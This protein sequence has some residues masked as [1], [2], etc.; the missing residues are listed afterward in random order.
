MNMQELDLVIIKHILSNKKNALEF[1]H[2][3]NEKIFSPD[4]WRFIKIILD[5]IRVYK[6][7]PTRKIIS[8]KNKHNETLLK[9][10][11]QLWDNIDDISIDE[12]EYKYDL[13]KIKNR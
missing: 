13:E 11:N 10:I 1:V 3:C 2:E 12:K 4:C 8:E 9:Y 7:I 5:H 6:E